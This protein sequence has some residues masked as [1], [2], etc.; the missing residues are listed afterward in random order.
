MKWLWLGLLVLLV[1]C[2]P[3]ITA[4]CVDDKS[5]SIQ[6]NEGPQIAITSS[7]SIGGWVTLPSETCK[8]QAAYGITCR[9]KT[10]PFLIELENVVGELETHLFRDRVPTSFPQ[11]YSPNHHKCLG[12]KSG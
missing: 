9:P 4:G 6:Y 8:R 11:F 2:A 10:Y 1:A 12:V 5:F 7:V 3:S